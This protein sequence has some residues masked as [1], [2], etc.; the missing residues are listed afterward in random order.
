MTV[1][2]LEVTMDND[3]DA[4]TYCIMGVYDSREKAEEAYET[5][6]KRDNDWKY[7]IITTYSQN[8]EP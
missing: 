3:S 7:K 1:Y 5:L 8:G 4:N 6:R 2:V